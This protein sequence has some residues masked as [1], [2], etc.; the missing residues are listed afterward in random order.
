MKAKA[1]IPSDVRLNLTKFKGAVGG[2]CCKN[3]VKL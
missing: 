2:F 1:D 3:S